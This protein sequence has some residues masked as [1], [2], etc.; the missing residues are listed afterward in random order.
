MEQVRICLVGAGR[1]G[2]VHGDVCFFSVPGA[3]I[4]ANK[5]IQEGMPV[6]L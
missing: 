3:V 4:A 6:D 5:S 2:E 1:A